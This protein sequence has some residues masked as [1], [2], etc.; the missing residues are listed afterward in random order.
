MSTIPAQEIKQRGISAVDK[1]LERGPVH[2]ISRNRPRYV[3]IT[4]EQ[5]QELMDD[6]DEAAI[7]RLRA[8]LADVEAGRVRRFE[9]DEALRAHILAYGTGVDE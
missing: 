1:L 5:Y 8:S 9:D 7:A 3:V 6:R 4:E 2:V